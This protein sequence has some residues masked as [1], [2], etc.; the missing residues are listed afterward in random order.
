VTLACG[1]LLEPAVLAATGPA[2]VVVANLP[3]LTSDEASAAVGSLRYEPRAALD[4]GVD[5]LDLIRRLLE[6]LAGHLAPTG[7]A[8]LEIGADQAPSISAFV[9]TVEGLET[10]TLVDDL[11]GRPRILRIARA[12]A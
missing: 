7:C 11:A 6:D 4:G 2:D 1:D 10:P 3:Y 5:G 8:L 9:A 12:A